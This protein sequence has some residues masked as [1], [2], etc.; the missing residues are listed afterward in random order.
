MVISG[1]TLAPGGFSGRA[2]PTIRKNPLTGDL[3]LAYSYLNTVTGVAAVPPCAAPPVGAKYFV[4]ATHVAQSTDNGA[5][6]TYKGELYSDTAA[7]DP[8]SGQT[9]VY[10]HEV[11]NLYPKLQ[12]GVV[13]W[14]GIHQQYFATANSNLGTS[15][16]PYT[17]R[18]NFSVAAADAN[19]G[20][21]NLT[22]ATPY[23]MTGKNNNGHSASYPI[24]VNLSTLPGQTACTAGSP[25]P[26]TGN[27]SWRE[28]SLIMVSNHLYFQTVCSGGTNVSQF[29]T[30]I[31]GL[32]TPTYSF[33]YVGNF[34]TPTD[35][36]T[37]CAYFNACTVPATTM[38]FTQEDIAVNNAGTGTEF[39]VSVVQYIA[40]NKQSFGCVAAPLASVSPP[41]FTYV[42]G[43]VQIDH[44]LIST[45]S[46]PGPDSCSYQPNSV[47]GMLLTRQFSGQHR[48]LWQSTINP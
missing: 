33:S 24:D 6:W 5:T 31:S 19:G 39:I 7:C 35:A 47:G 30:D 23:Y 38:S 28:P 42:A 22:A 32:P 8:D 3:W 4:L 11:M 10:D 48:A 17:V 13:Y 37:L 43:K 9:V 20:P 14:F 18:F 46:V 26:G 25:T 2:D 29:T 21:F 40:G 16:L 41:A 12:A 15:A 34:A 45:D 1:E 36:Q 44:I 27:P